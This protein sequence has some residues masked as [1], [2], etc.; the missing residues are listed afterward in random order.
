MTPQGPKDLTGASLSPPKAPHGGRRPSQNSDK[1]A[2]EKVKVVLYEGYGVKAVLSCDFCGLGLEPA[3]LILTIEAVREGKQSQR[4]YFYTNQEWLRQRLS[5]RLGA[6]LTACRVELAE[7]EKACTAAAR[8]LE[9]ALPMPPFNLFPATQ[10][11]T[12]VQP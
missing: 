12:R 8:V 10:F 9:D 7:R 1:A 11:S 4:Q 5:M 6:A 3:N 2:Y